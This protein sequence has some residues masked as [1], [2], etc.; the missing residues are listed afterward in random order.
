MSVVSVTA[1]FI[2]MSVPIAAAAVP[3]EVVY[4]SLGTSLAAGSQIDEH[5]NT[6]PSSDQSYTDQLYQRVQGRI[7]ADLEH[8]KLGCAGETTDQF[9]GGTNVFDQPSGCAA[10]YATGSQV[11]DALAAIA[12]GNVVLVTIDMGANDIIQAQFV[13]A[14]DPVC[15][16]SEVGDVV[17]KIGAILA[18]VR[19]A[20]YE[21]PIIAMNYYNPQ[22]AAAIGFYPGIEGQ[23]VADPALA[24]VT[25]QLARGFN[26][27]LGQ[28][29]GHFAVPVADV[30]SA[31]NAGDFGDEAP[32]NGVSDNVDRLC[33]LS[34]M[35]PAE[36]DVKANIHL[37]KH[38]YRVVAKSFHSIVDGIEFDK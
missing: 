1:L 4:L 37:T 35:C 7:G 19:Q 17:L 38:G 30:Y 14:G 10:D 3:D 31:F 28:V 29:Y 2:G 25:D 5:G 8:V 27:A 21:G 34:Y 15:I 20:G 11:G 32:E 13:C 9:F 36:A 16:G 24:V 26:D 18:T 23:Q 12:A 33:A 6:T 22:V